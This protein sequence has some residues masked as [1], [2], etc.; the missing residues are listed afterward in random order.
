MDPVALRLQQSATDR[1]RIVG[2]ARQKGNDSDLWQEASERWA[3]INQMLHGDIATLQLE[4]EFCD[5]WFLFFEAAKNIS[6]NHPAM[7]RLVFHVLQARMDK[8]WVTKVPAPS[9]LEHEHEREALTR[10]GSDLPFFAHYMTRF[11]VD[12]YGS[13]TLSQRLGSASFL[14]RLAG[15]GVANDHLCCI[16]LVLFR[17]TLETPRPFGTLKEDD[18]NGAPGV[19]KAMS[20]LTIAEL[21]VGLNAFAFGAGRK[22]IDLCHQADTKCS[23]KKDSELRNFGVKRWIGWVQRLRQISRQAKDKELSLFAVRILD[24][25][26]ITLEQMSTPIQ[27]EF[28]VSA[29]LP[30][31]KVQV[32]QSTEHVNMPGDA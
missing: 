11:L 1:Q 27:K 9:L 16:A 22:I 14:A 19:R 7:D 21:I 32:H 28:N 3:T 2:K 26:L 13:M 29:A 5:L 24:S 10:L 17:E 12:S 25:M 8:L 15:L 20:E 31:Y 30:G 6:I 4:L 18:K 23:I